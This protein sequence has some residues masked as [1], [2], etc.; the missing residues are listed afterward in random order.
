MSHLY[1]H[2]GRQ[3]HSC[4]QFCVH[5]CSSVFMF[6]VLCSCSQF[7]VHVHSS[8]FMF[9]VLCSWL[10]F[11]VHVHSSVFVFAAVCTLN[12]TMQCS[13]LCCIADNESCVP[14]LSL[15]SSVF[16]F[17]HSCFH[18]MYVPGAH[19]KRGLP[20]RCT[21]PPH[22]DTHTHTLS[23]SLSQNFKK[24]SFFCRHGR[25]RLLYDIPFS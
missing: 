1:V 18:V 9:A 19:P 13:L 14:V 15:F 12:L 8:V 11:C 21:P 17:V 25:I 4:L 23:L 3:L 6:E 10:E 16:S 24:Y 22:T 7:C 5:V 20:G 2:F